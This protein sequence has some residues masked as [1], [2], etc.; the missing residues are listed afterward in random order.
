M[1]KHGWGDAEQFAGRVFKLALVGDDGVGKTA[2]VKR[3]LTG[4][5]EKKYVATIGVEVHPIEFDT[6]HGPIRF[7]V[8][9][10]AGQEKYG[11]LRSGYYIQSD[12][13]IL[14]FDVTSPTTYT[15]VP[16]WHRNF[17]RVCGKTAPMVLCANKVEVKER[18]V[19]RE[20]ITFHLG[21]TDEQ[22]NV[23]RGPM[24]AYCEISTKVGAQLKEPFLCLARELM[25]EP[26]LV[27]VQPLQ[28]GGEPGL[29]LPTT[30]AVAGAA[31]A[32]APR[33]DTVKANISSLSKPKP[34]PKWPATAEA[35]EE[36]EKR[37]T[38]YCW[39]RKPLSGHKPGASA[40]LQLAQLTL[41]AF[42]QG[43]A[44]TDARH[45]LQPQLGSDSSGGD[46]SGSG[47]SALTEY[48]GAL[49][50]ARIS[51]QRLWEL[52]GAPDS[53]GVAK[54]AVDAKG[55]DAVLVAAGVIKLFHRKR[56]L[57]WARSL[58]PMLAER[59]N[60]EPEPL[61]TA[62]GEGQGD[63]GAQPQVGES[64][65]KDGAKGAEEHE[66]QLASG[67]ASM[68]L[69]GLEAAAAAAA[70]GNLPPPR[71]AR[72]RCAPAALP[73]PP[74]YG[75]AV[76]T[77]CLHILLCAVQISRVLFYYR[78]LLFAAHGSGGDS[79]TADA[80]AAMP[81]T[82][83]SAEEFCR[84]GI[85]LEGLRRF[86]SE[87]KANIREETTTS[88]V[89]HA[90]IKHDA[91]TLPAGCRIYTE[92]TDPAKRYYSHSYSHAGDAAASK[93]SAPPAGT[94]SYCAAIASWSPQRPTCQGWRQLV[95]RP[96]VF[97]SHAWG[98]RFRKLLAALEAFDAAHPG[99]FFWFDC[100]SLDEHAT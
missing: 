34:A 37:A 50:A 31:A 11:G 89:C 48:E 58:Q 12:C 53:D 91:R 18:K 65:K 80:V 75:T 95:G 84:W 97:L 100:F 55:A 66:K 21:E 33:A 30:A 2:F 9:D 57:R 36:K 15:N 23:L 87:H 61:M 63:A 22:G 67:V 17:T 16:N 74:N 44:A 42:L 83:L 72:R 19:N 6:N 73:G 52:A 78:P 70:A 27:F 8:W 20:S 85:S 77:C 51:V 49:S 41:G 94:R 54:G 43:P 76:H 62:D 82:L 98:F 56:L 81:A 47:A 39:H 25:R 68:T 59:D 5:F 14:M 92:L 35:E 64:I 45:Q 86:A 7:N 60:L 4:E 99:T 24:T 88:D 29:S 90:I 46:G 26:D 79:I 13:A 40:Q 28:V 93:Q 38:S 32:A 96:T 3:H 69:G 1:S 10:V 71:A